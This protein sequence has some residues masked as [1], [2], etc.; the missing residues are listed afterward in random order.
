MVNPSQIASIPEK[1]NLWRRT[2]A[3]YGPVASSKAKGLPSFGVDTSY[4][5]TQPLRALL[6]RLLVAICAL[7]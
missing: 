5:T 6:T 4:W 3:R 1:S 2:L 7:P